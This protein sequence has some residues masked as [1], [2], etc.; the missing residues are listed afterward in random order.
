[1]SYDLLNLLPASAADRVILF[2]PVE[3]L[4]RPFGLNLFDIPD[5]KRID[6]SADWAVTAL[7]KAISTRQPLADDRRPGGQAPV[8]RS[9]APGRHAPGGAEVPE[10]S[11]L[12][13]PYYPYMAEHQTTSFDYWHDYLRRP[14][15][16]PRD[17]GISKEQQEEAGPILRRLDRYL[18][19][20]RLRNIL[21]QPKVSLNISDIM[22]SG[23][24]LIVRLPESELGSQ[25]AGLLGS[26]IL[27]HLFVATLG[28]IQ[29]AT[30][31][32]ASPSSS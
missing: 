30:R 6:V 23:K 11:G 20:E 27:S 7:K 29:P 12:P 5:P 4:D 31:S 24:I 18:A 14:G 21:G 1:M 9:G 25:A 13:D 28:Q 22:E 17:D 10:R 19:D 26:V 15:L 16:R 3:Q 2:D 32:S 8:L